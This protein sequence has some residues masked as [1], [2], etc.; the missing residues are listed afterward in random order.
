MYR[1]HKLHAFAFI[2][3]VI[4]INKIHDNTDFITDCRNDAPDHC[5]HYLLQWRENR[6][7]WWRRWGPLFIKTTKQQRRYINSL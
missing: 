3:G 4:L 6:N 5:F 2:S 7:N 1:T